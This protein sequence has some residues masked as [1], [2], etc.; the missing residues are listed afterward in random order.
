M[1]TIAHAIAM[2]KSTA[3]S[4]GSIPSSFDQV[5]SIESVWNATNGSRGAVPIGARSISPRSG[6]DDQTTDQVVA[7]DKAAKGTP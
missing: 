6:F 5:V 4:T 1:G 7:G 3:W 2:D